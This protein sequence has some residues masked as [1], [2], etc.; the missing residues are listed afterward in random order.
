MSN[1]YLIAST[2]QWNIDAFMQERHRFSGSWSIITSNEDLTDEL[3]SA[4]SPRYVFFLHWNWIVPASIL[5]SHE[6]VCF[7]MTDVPFGRGGSPLQNLIARGF[8]TTQLSAL[9]MTEELDAG[10]VYRKEEL[11]LG[12]SA[13]EIFHRSARVAI[14]IID[15]MVENEPVPVE[16]VGKVTKFARRRPAQSMIT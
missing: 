2:K 9:K 11:F 7:H 12:G 13:D 14:D 15:W 5:S 3:L 16:Q 4:L 6:C 8:E 1:T 10:P